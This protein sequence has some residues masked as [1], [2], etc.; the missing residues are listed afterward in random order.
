MDDERVRII[1]D[2]PCSSLY[3]CIDTIDKAVGMVLSSKF[4]LFYLTEVYF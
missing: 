1:D 3:Q 2:Y 4:L